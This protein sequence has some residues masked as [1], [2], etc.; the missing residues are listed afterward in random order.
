[1]V[2]DPSRIR[3]ELGWTPEIPLDRMLDDVLAFWRA[4][5][6]RALP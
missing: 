5:C 3:D 6:R 4:N 1:V 2:G